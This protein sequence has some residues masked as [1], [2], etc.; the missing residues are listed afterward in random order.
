[1]LKW[2]PKFCPTPIAQASAET[3]EAKPSTVRPATL[4]E[5]KTEIV[6]G[7]ETEAVAL[8]DTP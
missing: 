5:A 2:L 4:A 8:S 7:F 1:M 6:P 3:S